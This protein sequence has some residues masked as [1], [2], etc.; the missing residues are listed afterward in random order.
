[1]NEYEWKMN[2]CPQHHSQILFTHCFFYDSYY[3][4]FFQNIFK[5]FICRYVHKSTRA[6][7]GC[8]VPQS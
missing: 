8:Q 7:G 6:L 5:L 3:Y 1:M 4:C 2:D